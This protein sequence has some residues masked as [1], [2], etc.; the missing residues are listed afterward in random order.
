M[1]IATAWPKALALCST[2]VLASCYVWWSQEKANARREKEAAGQTQVLP[3]SKSYVFAGD[4]AGDDHRA[5]SVEGKSDGWKGGGQ[6][7]RT[8]AD[9]IAPDPEP[10]KERTM[11]PS[12]K[13]GLVKQ[14]QQEEK[15]KSKEERTMLPG[16]KSAAFGAINR[17]SIDD[18]LNS[19]E[20]EKGNEEPEKQRTV[21]PGSKSLDR[22]LPP[23]DLEKK[24]EP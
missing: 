1:R 24:T 8:N 23:P 18:I 20:A 16:S 14:A 12:S 2:L 21:L 10:K 7:P 4:P 9:F 15:E 17:N 3:G 11:L 6:D 5:R 22:I 13:I 19:Q